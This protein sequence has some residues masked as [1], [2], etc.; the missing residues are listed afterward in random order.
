MDRILIMAGLTAIAVL[1]IYIAKKTDDYFFDKK[2]GT[3]L[4]EK[5]FRSAK[6]FSQGES[7]DGIRN[8]LINCIDFDEADIDEVL[9][10]SYPHR[11]DADGGYHAFVKAVKKVLTK[12]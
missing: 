7:A 3:D 12:Y 4:S 9:S 2:T 5:V 10:M 6:A 8:I 1:I 11:N